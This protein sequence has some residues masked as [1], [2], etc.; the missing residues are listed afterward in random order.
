M[1]TGI[2]ASAPPRNHR[3]KVEVNGRPVTIVGVAPKGFTG[4]IALLD[5]QGYLPLG[6]A[7]GK[8][9][10][11]KNFLTDRATVSMFIL[12]RLKSGVTLAQAQ[13]LLDVVAKQLAREYPRI[14]NWKSLRASALTSAPP[15]TNPVNPIG[16]T[17]AIFLSF[18]A[19]VLLLAC[20]NLAGLLLVRA[21]I[22]A[23]EM[24]VRSA[25]GAARSRLLRQLLTDSLV[26]ALAGC[27]GGILLGI[28]AS[29]ALNSFPVGAESRLISIS[30]P[31]G[32]FMP[33]P[34]PPRWQPGS[35]SG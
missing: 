7:A 28:A 13:P 27:A 8:I 10:D 34:S 9:E 23:R 25:L 19:L 22:R 5:T 30:R 12:A 15:H 32:E 18:A 14:D 26:L 16:A 2:P 33:S 31:V 4:P 11:Q 21:G 20:V 24:A 29:K 6:M 1:P 3:P 17:A 35:P